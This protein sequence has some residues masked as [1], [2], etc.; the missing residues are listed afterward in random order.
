VAPAAVASASVAVAVVV[1]GG[2]GV[3]GGGSGDGAMLRAR[4]SC[5]PRTIFAG[6]MRTVISSDWVNTQ[7]PE[8]LVMTEVALG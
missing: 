8:N 2:G 4:T 5:L 6:R 3:G 1:V 7:A